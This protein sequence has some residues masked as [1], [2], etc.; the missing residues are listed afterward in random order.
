MYKLTPVNDSCNS[1]LL[2]SAYILKFH[3]ELHF[4]N[5]TH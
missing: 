2:I 1:E 3:K 5:Q 4:S